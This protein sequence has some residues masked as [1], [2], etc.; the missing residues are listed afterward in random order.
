M[1]FLN[2][3]GVLGVVLLI[4]SPPIGQAAAAPPYQADAMHNTANAVPFIAHNDLQFIDGMAPHHKMAI[5]MAQVEVQKGQRADVKK[6]AQRIISSQTKELVEM[7]ALRKQLTG[8]SQIP[9]P[10]P[11]PHMMADLAAMR[12]AHGSQLDMLFLQH[13][14]PHHADAISM[15]HR[16]LPYLHLAE[17]RHMARTIITSQAHEIGEM[18]AM[19]H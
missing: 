6:L 9:P 18:L 11:D 5:E 8:S 15:A 17:L 10:K 16:A 2:T 13:M 4:T 1:K 19:E 12:A 7:E 3:A 14:I